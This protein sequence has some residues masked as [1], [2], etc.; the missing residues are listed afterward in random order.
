M[1][2]EYLMQ[3]LTNKLVN[4][5]KRIRELERAQEQ[6]R[7]MRENNRRYQTTDGEQSPYGYRG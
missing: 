2:T 4:M 3:Q 5:E 6:Q 1:T 7:Q